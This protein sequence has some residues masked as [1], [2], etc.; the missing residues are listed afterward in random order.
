MLAFLH[1]AKAQIPLNF[2]ATDCNGNSKN[3][4]QVLGTTGKAIIIMSKGTDCSICQ[5][6]APGWQSWAAQNTNDVEVWGAITY[7]YSIMNFNPPCTATLNW[8]SNYNWNDIF[9]FPDLNRDFVEIAMPR[10]YVYSP[11]DSTIVYSGPNSNTARNMALQESI[12]GIRENGLLSDLNYFCNASNLWIKQIPESINQI[13]LYDI[14]GH[15]I[16]KFNSIGEQQQINFSGLKGGIYL[17]AFS[18][19]LQRETIKIQYLP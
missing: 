14:K 5:S 3:I 18:S 12:V 9:T 11:K 19:G 17:I 1:S 15:Q 4:H 13:E 6:S 7:R 10:Y 8:K 16:G 2:T